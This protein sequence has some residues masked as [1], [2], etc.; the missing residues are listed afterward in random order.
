MRWASDRIGDSGII[1]FVTGNGWIDKSFASGMRKSFEEEFNNIYVINLRGDIRKNMLSKG[2][3]KEGEN[4][5]GQGSMTGSAITFLV[6]N[7]VKT[8]CEIR[9]FEIG[10]DLKCEQKLNFLRTSV[11]ISGLNGGF[12]LITPDK[13]NDWTNKRDHSFENYLLIGEKRDKDAKV[14][15]DSYTSGVKTQRD[16]WCYNFSRSRLSKNINAT[17]DYYNSILDEYNESEVK[18]NFALY[19]FDNDDRISWSR[20][21]KWDF[22]KLKRLAYDQSCVVRSYYRPFTK[23]WLYYN[24]SLNEMLYQTK[25]IFPDTPEKKLVIGV[26]GIGAR[27][28]FSA[29]M[30]DGLID[31]EIL[32]KGQNFPLKLYEKIDA[33]DGDLFAQEGT[34][35]GYRVKDGI[36]DY[37]LKHFQA[38]YSNAAITKE[39]IFY[40]VYGLLHSE[41]YRARFADNLSKELPRIPAVKQEAD[42]WAFVEAGRKLGDLHVNYETVEPYPATFA[43]GALELASIDDPVKFYRV[44]KMRFAGKRP[45]L[46][47]T[48][49]HYNSNITI[50]NIPLAAYD[51]VVN[52]KSALDWVMERQ[53]VKTDTA[54]GIVNDANDYANETMN[55]PAYPLKLFLRVITVSLQTTEIV[56]NLPKLEI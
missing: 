5:F 29:L 43:E 47:K 38:A 17:I 37:G 25:R 53:C 14:L 35:N 48:I 30:S 3:A 1:G 55:D 8:A 50:T 10:D 15:F 16:I 20:A 18:G 44:E 32:E 27:G 54:S 22:E 12:E 39:D 51:Y 40:Y 13:H 2:R 21:L 49:V 41:E 26:T 7:P 34:E 28:G 6:K 9:Y 31:L 19:T 36:T 23:N 56:K 52:G 33:N 42:F 24:K 11:N 45:K 4:I 46:D